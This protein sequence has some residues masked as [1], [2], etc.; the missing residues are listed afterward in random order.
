MRPLGTDGCR[1][2][3]AEVYAN[4][5]QWHVHWSFSGLPLKVAYQGRCPWQRQ[6]QDLIVSCSW[7]EVK[8]GWRKLLS[9]VAVSCTPVHVDF[10]CSSR[11]VVVNALLC[12]CFIKHTHC[13]W[14]T[15]SYYNHIT[16]YECSYVINWKHNRV[17]VVQV[18]ISCGL[19]NNWD[20]VCTCPPALT[21]QRA[22]DISTN[23]SVSIWM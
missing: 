7:D 13:Y 17:D 10:M 22:W 15:N 19:G 20:R 18:P 4:S 14:R 12:S 8:V 23:N 16:T 11:P 3:D 2:V 5:F 1:Q 6:G 9:Y 21:D